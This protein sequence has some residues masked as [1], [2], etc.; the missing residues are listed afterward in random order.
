[1]RGARWRALLAVVVVGLALFGCQP[2]A[3]VTLEEINEEL[4]L[5]EP[6]QQMEHLRRK[7]SVD[8]VGDAAILE[9]TDP[10]VLSWY[11]LVVGLDGTGSSEIPELPAGTLGPDTNLRNELLKSLYRSKVPGSPSEVLHS[12]DSAPVVATAVVPPLAR[13][14]QRLDVVIQALGRT[15]SLRGGVLMTTPLRQIVDRPGRG[16]LYGD[17]WAYGEGKVTLSTGRLAFGEVTPV[18]ETVGY[19]PAGAASTVT[20]FLGLRL[21]RADAYA[22]ALIALT[23]ND[24]FPNTALLSSVQNFQSIRINVPEYYRSEWDRFA[25]VLLEVRCRPPRGRMLRAY[26]NRLAAELEGQD[27]VLAQEATYKLEAL[28]PETVP[29]LEG[30]LRSARREARLR[31]ATTLAAM[32]EPV[33]IASLMGFLQSGSQDERRV[34]AR[35]L[36]FYTQYNVREFQKKLLADADPEVRYRALLGL[37]QT[38]EDAPYATQEE[39]RGE[40]FKVTRVRAAGPPALVVKARSPRRLVFFGPDLTLK[41]PFKLE[42]MKE[43]LIE[44]QD[45]SSLTIRYQIYGQPNTLPIGSLKVVDLVRVL[46]HIKV[47]V[48][49]IM[50]LIFKLS[51]ADAIGGEVLFLDE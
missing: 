49:D 2:A 3:R 25:R 40:D 26:I 13:P 15:R 9:G 48:N 44:A 36:N 10:V 23:I 43:V 50:D 41:P 34:A 19:V 39:A 38:Q 5:L 37:E 47:T 35:Y 45:T 6:R 21:R 28:G 14:N 8:R 51:R 29:A 18:N 32:R 42:H 17:A 22:A 46:G 16:R 30:V 24:R 4:R 27:P 20:G 12:L 31:A 1:M 33:G 7:T 11:S